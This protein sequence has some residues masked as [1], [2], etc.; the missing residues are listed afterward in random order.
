MDN[1][2]QILAAFD[3]PAAAAEPAPA[4]EPAPTAEP[5]PATAPA[6][7]PAAAPAGQ[8]TD[9]A[10]TEPQA[11]PEPQ[12][13]GGKQNQAFAQMRTQNKMLQ[14]TLAQIGQALGIQAQKP[15]ELV[16]A[17][18]QKVLQFQSQEN[19]I[20]VEVLQEL[21]EARQ[22]KAQHEQETHRNNAL[23]SFQKVKDTF[24]LDN[25][26][27]NE[28]ADQLAAAGKNPFADPLDLVQEYRMLNFDKILAAERAKAI[29]EEQARLNK[30]ASHSST[31]VKATGVPSQP[32]VT[33]TSVSDLDR[34]LSANGFK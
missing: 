25:N 9:P 20:P 15:D 19:N 22:L 21:E 18:T 12:F 10:Q 11:D 16:S 8:A 28:F 2:D 1:L 26:A 30:V 13:V 4:V 14:D 27:L 17:I 34:L 6:A 23:L 3:N 31:P 7:E 29:A 33:V 32:A 24:A 5:A